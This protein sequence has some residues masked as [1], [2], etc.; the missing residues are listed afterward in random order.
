[1]TNA[2][3]GLE[4]SKQIGDPRL[5][6]YAL[7]QLGAIYQSVGD[8][9]NALRRYE[10][11]LRL[12]RETRNRV[13][14]AVMLNRVGFIHELNRDRRKALAHYRE[15]LPISRETENRAEEINALHHIARAQRDLGALA[16]AR[17]Q[18]E[19]AIKL[20]ESTREQLASRQLRESYFATAQTSYSLYI[21]VL[22]LLHKQRPEEGLNKLALQVSER[23]R[24]RSFREM[25]VE[26][27]A[28]LRKDVPPQLFERQRSLQKDL[29]NKAARQQ[30]MLSMPHS[31]EEAENAA[32]ELRSLEIEYDETQRQIKQ[33]APRYAALTQ[34][35]SL[36]VEEIQRRLLDDDTALLEYALGDVRSYLW[37]VAPQKIVSYELPARAV[38]E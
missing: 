35:Q 27:R 5:E 16:E 4:L 34:P 26:S 28:D 10:G 1:L 19:T 31:P 17:A 33:A 14:E 9:P 23:A 18:V 29:N 36:T 22:M 15:A 21:D 12:S 13:L 11:S 3:R 8:R 30:V 7:N 24:V 20:I 25:L 6:A 2:T 37:L 32:R 38:I